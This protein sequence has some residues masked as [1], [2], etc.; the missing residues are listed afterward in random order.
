MNSSIRIAGGLALLLVGTA[1]GR[2]QPP[3]GPAPVRIAVV[4]EVTAPATLS[5]VGD[6][7]PVRRSIVS[8]KEASTVIEFPFRDG[9]YVEKDQVVARLETDLLEIQLREAEATLEG[10][11]SR[12]EELENGTRPEDIEAAVAQFQGAVARKK[13]ADARRLRA[14]RLSRE[15][16]ASTDELELALATSA[17][18]E[19]EVAQ[20]QA[21]LDAAQNGPRREMIEQARA[22][23]RGQEAVRDRL[24]RQIERHQVLAPFAGS[25]VV[26]H[27]EVGEWLEEG[28]PVVDIVDLSE[29][30]LVLPVASKYVHQLSIGSEVRIE[31]ESKGDEILVGTIRAIVPEADR[32]SRLVPVKVRLKNELQDRRPVIKA[33]MIARAYFSIGEAGAQLQVTKDALVLGAG[34]AVV[35]RL[36][37]GPEPGQTTVEAVSV[38]LGAARGEKIEIRGAISAGDRVVTQG[39]ERLHQGQEVSVLDTPAKG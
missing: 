7:E 33:G 22:Q 25:V 5:V 6:V 9:D 16:A 13:L 32:R 38:T 17:T 4:E 20:F 28:A 27:T 11:R 14:E 21:A 31:I 2:A 18:A 29:V 34:P 3:S 30:D 19:F 26:E 8:S 1:A 36:V 37:D 35:Y 12:L 23:V 39:N 15:N 10:A 24:T